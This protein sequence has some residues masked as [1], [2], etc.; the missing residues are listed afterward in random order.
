LTWGVQKLGELGVD[1]VV[2]LR[3]ARTVRAW[4]EDRRDR[5]LRRLEVVARE[6]AMQSRQP[7]VMRVLQPESLEEAVAVSAVVL[8]LHQGAEA[9]LRESLPE[10]P[11]AIRLV[12][13]PEG[14]FADEEVERARELGAE[15]V[16]LGPSILRTETAA[17]VGAALV[18]HR[19]G[20]LG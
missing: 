10:D 8:M 12:V 1:E 16:T 7:F 5:A 19:Y 4:D 13:G 9:P 11:G 2:P 20:R 18:L 17:V 14:G 3:S 15:P 6:A